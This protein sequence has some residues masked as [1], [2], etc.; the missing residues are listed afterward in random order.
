MDEFK[1]ECHYCHFLFFYGELTKDHVVP[2]AKGGRDIVENVVPSCPECNT[3]K[4]DFMPTC[5][6]AFCTNA[7]KMF[8][9]QYDGKPVVRARYASLGKAWA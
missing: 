2:Q 9:H 8:E 1:I 5:A 6:C 7:V 3:R 4:A